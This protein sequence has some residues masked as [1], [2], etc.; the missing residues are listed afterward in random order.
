MIHYRCF[1]NDDPPRVVGLW[2]TCL[3]GPRAVPLPRQGK[4][5]LEYFTFSKPYFDPAGLI[6]ALDGGAAVGL[7][8]AGF[9]ANADGT[10]LDRSTG[11]IC[12]LGVMASHRLRGV[13][14]EL[15]R[16]G[17]QYLRDRGATTVV[18][19][20]MA[21]ANPFTF[22]LYGG[23]D[24]AGFLDS[25]PA[26][27]PFFEKRG[28]RAA[29]SCGVFRR[30]LEKVTLPNDPRFAGLR[31]RYEIVAAPY[32][33]AGWWRECVLGPI[34]AVVYRLEDKRTRRTDAEAI[35]WDMEL[36]TP[37][38]GVA[39]VGL[40]DLVVA[41]EQRQQGLAKY[42]LSQVLRHLRDQPFHLFEARVDLDND[43]AMALLRSLQFDQVEVGHG[44]RR[45]A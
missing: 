24:S 17:E 39:C 13:G 33:H 27:R 20:P 22:G 7:V 25:H 3:V 40:V 4:T 32:T 11:V 30:P 21:P 37:A 36:Y 44:Y 41:Q 34:E 23:A 14:S 43:A 2:N 42:L 16:R 45:E 10:S 12:V 9:A 35:L 6:L 8:H 19:G 31:A 29:R 28:Y 5:L 15:L 26:A 38:W 1:R 18:A